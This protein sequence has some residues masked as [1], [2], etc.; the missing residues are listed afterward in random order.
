MRLGVRLRSVVAARAVLAAVGLCLGLVAPVQ[1]QQPASVRLQYDRGEGATSCPDARAFA[2]G[3]AGR[4]WVR[5][6]RRSGRRSGPGCGR[7]PGTS[8]RGPHRDGRRERQDQGGAA[9]HLSEAGLHGA[10]GD[11]GAGDRH[12]ARSVPCDGSRARPPRPIRSRRR[13][14]P[15]H[16]QPWSRR[17]P[18]RG[19]TCE[20]PPP[21]FSPRWRR[22]L[23]RAR[24]RW[25]GRWVWP[26]SVERAQSLFAI[27]A[28]RCGSRRGGKI[29]RSRSKEVPIS[30]RSRA[31]AGGPGQHVVAGRFVGALCPL[32]D[33]GRLR[34]GDG[35]RPARRRARAGR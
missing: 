21:R 13:R 33:P 16:R 30:P 15:L 18:F 1:A 17:V 20:A 6:L 22:H 14:Q 9:V 19:P 29:C 3:V 12:R 11:D 4:L 2:D 27:S 24:R 10:G 25:P 28:R 35:R 32:A 7:P 34:S 8:S 5:A 23:P 31:A 26:S